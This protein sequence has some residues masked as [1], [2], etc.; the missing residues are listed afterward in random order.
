MRLQGDLTGGRWAPLK[1]DESLLPWRK[2]DGTWKREADGT[3]VA[4][5]GKEG[6]ATLELDYDLGRSMEVKMKVNFPASNFV[7]ARPNGRPTPV[8]FSVYPLYSPDYRECGMRLTANKDKSSLNASC[9]LSRTD[10]KVEVLESNDLLIRVM[11]GQ[12]TITFNGKRVGEAVSTEA[13]K[14]V[15]KSVLRLGLEG[16]QSNRV[17][18]VS[19]IEVRLDPPQP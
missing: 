3:L 19:D 8:C 13:A 17:V 10:G 1:P 15:A 12:M 5:T 11:D 16:G 7:P 2:I 18:R 14:D 4:D 9:S 6:K